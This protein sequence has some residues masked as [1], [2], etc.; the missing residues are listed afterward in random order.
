MRKAKPKGPIV[1][2]PVLHLACKLT[3]AQTLE[4]GQELATVIQD[5]DG[6]IAR[7]TQI[8]AGLKTTLTA[9]EARRSSVALK[10]ARREEIREVQCEARLDGDELVSWRLDT[11]DELGRRPARDEEKQLETPDLRP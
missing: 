4:A 10:V 6:E 5:L 3:D 7:Q 9:L 1:R 11:G 2:R 8:K